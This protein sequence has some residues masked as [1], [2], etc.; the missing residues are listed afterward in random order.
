MQN[1]NHVLNQ[2]VRNKKEVD[3][4][5]IIYNTEGK[6]FQVNFGDTGFVF[7]VCPGV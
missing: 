1:K 3:Y 2:N 7:T 6:L 4:G 5:S